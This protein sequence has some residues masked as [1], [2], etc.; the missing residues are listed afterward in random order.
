MAA[1]AEGAPLLRITGLSKSFAGT[2]AL[3]DV[4]LDLRAGEILGLVGQNGSGKSTLIKVLAGY[5]R[6]DPGA[7]AVLAGEE[8]AL[9]DAAGAADA[10]L[11]FVH[12][13]L[14]LVPSLGALDN[15]ALG[16]GYRRSRLGTISWRAE[17]EAAVELLGQLGYRFD[18]TRPVGELRASERTGIAIARAVEGFTRGARVLVLDEPTASLPAAE[19]DRLF[20]VV[21]RVNAAGVAIVYVSH[22]FQEIF[23][24]CDRVTVLKDGAHV[25]TRDVP[26]L[27][28]PGLVRL[29]IGRDLEGPGARHATAARSEERDVALRLRG[30]VG[31]GIEPFDLEVARGE[32]VGVAGVTGSGRESLGR[33]AFGSLPREGLVEVGSTAVTAGSP[34]AS[35][36][37][38]MAYVPADRLSNAAFVDMT[39]R[40]NLTISRLRDVSGRRGLLRDRERQE[41]LRW[42]TD[43]EVKPCD[44]EARLATLS[45]G[46]QQKVMLARALR[47]GPATLV[48]D[49]PTQGVD[50]GAKRTIHDIVRRAAADG[51]GVLVLATESE[52]LLAL[53]DRVAVMV[54]GRCIGVFDTAGLAADDLTELTMGT[55]STVAD[56]AAAAPAAPTAPVVAGSVGAGR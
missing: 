10:G 27:T 11:R 45:G 56:G 40:E 13:D 44:P 47:L 46:N 53:C 21:R 22:R 39:L 9:G 18:L 37:A 42:L 52:E 28:E 35:I 43:L 24:L 19:A 14:G 26:D 12:Q 6:P 55:A 50:V 49:E 31:E 1:H 5:H 15:L 30:L 25:A 38:G 41:T 23:E 48:L 20:E 8:F 34:V 3:A 54:A 29:T 7:T 17:R 33:L 32:I 51:A 2:R 36:A 16:R 4:D